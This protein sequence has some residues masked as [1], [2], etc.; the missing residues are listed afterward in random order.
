MS[1]SIVESIFR[2]LN[3]LLERFHQSFFLYLMTS[4]DSFIAVG[5]YL[6]API[7]IS[8]GMTISGLTLWGETGSPS[9]LS[10]SH[11]GGLKIKSGIVM[12]RRRPVGPAVLIIGFTQLIGMGFFWFITSL[13]PTSTSFVR[14]FSFLLFQLPLL[15]KNS[16]LPLLS[17]ITPLYSPLNTLLPSSPYSKSHSTSF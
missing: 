11:T 1:F 14:L 5:N 16:S 13:D 15:T 17:V 12:K 4:V 7:L 6:A 2:S 3:N 9:P 10:P 8:A